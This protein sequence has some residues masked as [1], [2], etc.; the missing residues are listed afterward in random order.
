M[1]VIRVL[2]FMFHL[3]YTGHAVYRLSTHTSFAIQKLMTFID[4][5]DSKDSKDQPT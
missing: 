3:R 5:K 1:S 2:M 4:S